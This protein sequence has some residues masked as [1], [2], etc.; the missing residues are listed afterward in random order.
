MLQS[1]NKKI[2]IYFFLFLMIATFNNK[3]LN[4]VNFAEIKYISIKG[5]DIINNSQ[6]ENDIKFLIKNNL[7]FLNKT[8]V[9]EVI[10]SNNLVENYSVFKEYPSTLNITINKT[11]F[12]AKLKKNNQNFILGSNGKL[13]EASNNEIDL[14]FIFGDFETKNFF[15]LKKAIDQ[16]DLDYFDLRKLFFFKSGRWDIET[17]DGLL[18]KLPKRELTKSLKLLLIFLDEHN[19]KK[20]NQIDLRQY[21]QIII[22][23]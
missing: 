19:E 15:K 4:N 13:I 8:K 2:S 10:S 20:I 14:P 9:S 7:F 23:E 21:N 12:L 16:T 5:L 1:K 3:N 18:I 6:L 11:I 22:N 17:K